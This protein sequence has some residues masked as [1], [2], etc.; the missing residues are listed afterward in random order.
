MKARK[1]AKLGL[2]S[3]AV[4]VALLAALVAS[5]V[6]AQEITISDVTV[7]PGASVD[8]TVSASS[9]GGNGLG[10]WGFNIQYDNTVVDVTACVG[11]SGSVCNP[12]FADDAVRITGAAAVGVDNVPLATITFTGVAEGRSDL[13]IVDRDG[14]AGFDTLADATIG[15]PADISG[16]VTAGGG[17]VTV[18]AAPPAVATATPRPLEAPPTAT[19]AA[20]ELPEVG[21]TATTDG[22]GTSVWL[23]AGLAGLAA[24]LGLGALGLRTRRP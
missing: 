24:V 18:S 20:E 3:A 15:A 11:A 1:V 21:I 6:S 23:V 14:V 2:V 5:P 19:E 7:A 17:T 13:T 4:A 16:S 8:V 22:G 10:S 12:N 9:I